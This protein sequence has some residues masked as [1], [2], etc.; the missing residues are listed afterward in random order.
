MG[1]LLGLV[2]VAAHT[3]VA[4]PLLIPQVRLIRIR[5]SSASI[6]TDPAVICIQAI[7]QIIRPNYPIPP[8]N[9]FRS[10]KVITCKQIHI[11]RSQKP[12]A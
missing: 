5:A 2:N 11:T 4:A 9:R 10:K 3:T 6:K 7:N 12:T 1:R 8:Q